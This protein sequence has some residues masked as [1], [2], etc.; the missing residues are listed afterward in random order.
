VRVE[1]EVRDVDEC[2]E[3]DYPCWYEEGPVPARAR[4]S[5]A[6]RERRGKGAA[7]RRVPLDTD[8]FEPRFGQ[9]RPDQVGKVRDVAPNVQDEPLRLDCRGWVGR[10]PR[11]ELGGE[12]RRGPI[13]WGLR[14]EREGAAESFSGRRGGGRAGSDGRK[15]GRTR[16]RE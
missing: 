2:D 14:E 13:G 7:P 5:R 3:H 11:R 10:F 4:V 9:E 8:R 16:S 6:R 12:G 1:E 15:G